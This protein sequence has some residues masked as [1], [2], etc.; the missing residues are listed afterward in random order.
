MLRGSFSQNEKVT[1]GMCWTRKNRNS[2]SAIKTI[3]LYV[4]RNWSP[5]KKEKN[6]LR[7]LQAQVFFGKSF[8]LVFLMHFIDTKI[9]KMGNREV[10]MCHYLISWWILIGIS[11]FCACWSLQCITEIRFSMHKQ[12]WKIRAHYQ[13]HLGLIGHFAKLLQIK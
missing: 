9:R 8:L 7:R 1:L 3:I 5:E 2:K 11:V 10:S 6:C 4:C 13:L 12:L